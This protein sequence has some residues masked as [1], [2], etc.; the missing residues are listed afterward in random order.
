M[1]NLCILTIFALI[2]EH[3]SLIILLPMSYIYIC[4]IILKISKL[5]HF[6]Q[7]CVN[8]VKAWTTANKYKLSDNKTEL[9]SVTSKGPSVS[10]AYFLQSLVML[11]FLSINFGFKL[12]FYLSVNHHVSS[13][14]L[15]SDFKLHRLTSISKLLTFKY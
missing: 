2:N 14:A 4:V 9:M 5:L 15:R 6:M 10:I 11:K 13:T 12:C 7:S 3:L 1:F 8:E